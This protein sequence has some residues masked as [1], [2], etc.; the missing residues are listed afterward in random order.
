[1]SAFVVMR[2]SACTHV[3]RLLRLSLPKLERLGVALYLHERWTS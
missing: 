2:Q 3:L 1:M